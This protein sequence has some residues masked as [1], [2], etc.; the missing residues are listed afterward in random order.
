MASNTIKVL[1]VG[2][3][4][5]A[6]FG[7]YKL[8]N[9][10]KAVEKL[11][12]VVQSVKIGFASAFMQVKII[13]LVRNPSNETLS[14]KNFVGKIYIDSQ[15][16][17]NIDIPNPVKI[18]P[19]ADTPVTLS[20]SVPVTNILKAAASF[21]FSKKLPSEGIIDGVVNIGD[22]QLKIYKTFSFSQPS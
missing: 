22:V 2:A 12:V 18:S 17:G 4:I 20:A 6:I 1:G 8:S 9:K 5:L 11:Q 19:Q 21:L 7:I 15:T 14:F 13:L 3:G 10:S 16:L